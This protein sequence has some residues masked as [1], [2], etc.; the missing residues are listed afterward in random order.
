MFGQLHRLKQ[1]Y[2]D[3]FLV[4]HTREEDVLLVS[5]W[6][7]FDD[8]WYFTIR[9]CLY[10]LSGLGVPEFDMLVVRCR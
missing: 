8:I 3:D 7:E 5:V 4:L 9:E 6:I 2:L 10:A 1:T